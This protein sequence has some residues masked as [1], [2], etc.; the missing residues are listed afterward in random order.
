[1]TEEPNF[2]FY[3]PYTREEIAQGFGE[4]Y[5]KG[6]W[7]QGIVKAANDDQVLLV[8]FEK[9]G[10]H[11]FEPGVFVYHYGDRFLDRDLLLWQSQHRMDNDHAIT[12][13]ILD[14]NPS[15]LP[16]YLFCRREEKI[17]GVTQPFLYCGM[18]RPLYYHGERP[19]TAVWRI[20]NPL[21]E[22][23]MLSLCPTA[24]P[25][26]QVDLDAPKQ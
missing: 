21:P 26:R 23:V 1:M 7:D 6:R 3:A 25:C 10:E 13:R 18:V 12:R 9:T 16:T 15:A 11:P 19:I 4:T 8:T 2:H 17:S 5:N 14:L 20:A 24:G 22:R